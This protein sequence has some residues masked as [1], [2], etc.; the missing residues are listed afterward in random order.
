VS[1]FTDITIDQKYVKRGSLFIARE[2]S[3]IE[4]AIQNGAY[5]ILFDAPTQMIDSEIA[6]IKVVNIEDAL[7]RILRFHLLEKNITAYECDAITYDLSKQISTQNSF[8]P[9]HGDIFAVFKEL[10]DLASQSV[11]LFADS[12]TC[13]DLFTHPQSLPTSSDFK[14]TIIEQ[15]LF[16]TSFIYNDIYYERALLSPFF[17]PYLETLLELF[18]IKNIDFK[19]TS[20]KNIRHFE[21][22][23]TN[24]E[25]EIKDFGTSDKVL[26]FEPDF[27]LVDTQISFLKEQAGWAKIIYIIPKMHAANIQELENIYTYTA[28]EDIFAILKTTT[29]HFALIAEQNR[30]LLETNV[31]VKKQV[32]LTLDFD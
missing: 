1:I 15:T 24:K 5:G 8:I 32:Q 21:P 13:K 2:S 14:I 27:R 7:L 28:Q 26:I 30:T 12:F 11:I 22:V 18:R 17:I 9:V 25:F 23:F 29:F 4:A 16:E 3:E 10:W 6:W 31:F 19:I 20:F